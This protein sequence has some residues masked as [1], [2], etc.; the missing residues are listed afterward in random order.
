MQNSIFADSGVDIPDKTGLKALNMEKVE[1]WVGDNR[2]LWKKLIIAKVNEKKNTYPVL[3]SS[4]V[5]SNVC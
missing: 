5:F 4:T 1:E 2:V 3:Y